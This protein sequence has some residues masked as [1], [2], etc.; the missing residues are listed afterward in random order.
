MAVQAERVV[1]E[2]SHVETEEEEN[3]GPLLIG[4]L[5]VGR[6]NSKGRSR[7]SKYEYHIL[8]RVMVL[9]PMM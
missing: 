6:A 1:G 4:K 7:K 9:L 2:T 8:Y 3:F 5:E